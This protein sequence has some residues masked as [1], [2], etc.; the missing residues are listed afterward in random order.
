MVGGSFCKSTC[1]LSSLFVQ[2]H[3]M[4]SLC[5]R[6]LFCLLFPC[7]QSL[8]IRRDPWSCL[9]YG[10]FFEPGTHAGLLCKEWFSEQISIHGTQACVFLVEHAK[11]STAASL[12]YQITV[13]VICTRQPDLVM[14]ILISLP[15][16]YV[17]SVRRQLHPPERAVFPSPTCAS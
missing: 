17:K 16:A 7:H 3:R 13:N 12:P 14:C 8:S 1:I 10:S 5:F 15:T 2:L 9:V 6:F 4:A 11:A